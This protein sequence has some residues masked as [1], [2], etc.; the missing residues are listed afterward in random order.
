M[1][2]KITCLF[3]LTLIFSQSSP[4]YADFQ[5][6]LKNGGILTT[7][8]YWYEK[9]E[10][11]FYYLGGVVGMEKNAV[12]R[13]V[14]VATTYA[15]TA[16]RERAAASLAPLGETKAVSPGEAKNSATGTG[17]ATPPQ[18]KGAA[19]AAPKAEDRYLPQFQSMSS[20]A[21]GIP[22]MN[23]AELYAFSNDVMALKKE[24]LTKGLAYLYPDQ[25]TELYAV[26][27]KIE[28]AIKAKTQ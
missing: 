2:V 3:I 10:I 8:Y 26:G 19:P 14:P 5:I 9:N 7:A 22:T 11:R 4:L 1:R 21:Q 17:T 15:E 28:Q 6:L 13:V 18:A 27:D 16:I 12:V 20:R 24:V 25:L 23:T